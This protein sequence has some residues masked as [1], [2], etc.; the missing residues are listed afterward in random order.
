M[1]DG[2]SPFTQTLLPF[3]ATTLAAHRNP[4]TCL[5]CGLDRP[6]VAS[7]DGQR[8]E[9]DMVLIRP[10]VAHSVEIEGRAKVLYFN[11]LPFPLDAAVAARVPRRFSSLAIDA[12]DGRPDAQWELRDRFMGAGTVCPPAIARIVWDIVR[13]PM[14]RMSQAELARRTG[15]ERT[16]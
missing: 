3:V 9:A 12:L 11:G 4:V 7:A 6:L 13:D 10:G 15:L 8:T 2:P 5:L 16:R 14:T 1:T